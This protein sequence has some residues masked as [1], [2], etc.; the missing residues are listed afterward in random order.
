MQKISKKSIKEVVYEQLLE[1]IMNGALPPRARIIEMEIAHTFDCS[2]APIREALQKLQEDGLV[3][4]IPYTGAFVTNLGLEEMHECFEY[5]RMIELN[6]LKKSLHLLSSKDFTRLHEH[7]EQM[8]IAAS[9]RDLSV[10]VAHD[11]AFHRTILE[12]SEKRISLQMWSKLNLHVRR[13]IMMGHP[14]VYDN[15]EEI[16]S[17]HIPLLEALKNGSYEEAEH[18][19]R[20]H[21]NVEPLL[22]KL[23][24]Q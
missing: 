1:Q 22:E 11:M 8:S 16:A 10:L 6:A 7:I 9:Q 5:R 4:L 12:K 17:T 13:C 20:N 23:K 2:Q 15:W 18:Q 19:F 3:E 21:L 14:K 24:L